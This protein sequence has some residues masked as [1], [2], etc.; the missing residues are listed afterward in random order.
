MPDNNLFLLQEP[1]PRDASV[2]PAAPLFLIHDGGGTVFQYCSL[3]DLGRPT[4][5][6]TNPHFESGTSWGG[7]ICEMAKV[8]AGVIGRELPAGGGDIILGG[9]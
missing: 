1:K 6:I 2:S 4:Y 7:G 5:A 3:G 9:V 8:Y